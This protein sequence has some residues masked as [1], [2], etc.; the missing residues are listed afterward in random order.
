ME[1]RFG[2]PTDVQGITDIFNFYIENTN[3]RF[4]ELSL[5]VNNR[6][7]WFS[8]FSADSKYQIYVASKN[9]H[10]LG[11]AC[12]QP[13]RALEA[14][15]ETVEV[16]IYLDPTARGKGLGSA[17]YK[18]LFSALN[19]QKVHRILSAVALPN[20]ASV[21][22]HKSFGFREVGTFSEYATK[23]GQRISSVWLEKALDLESI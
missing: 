17:L 4:E 9:G 5:T 11:F 15:D 21:A 12:S 23:K 18:T 13:Y 22:L 8:Q 20:D 16:T 6:K 3:A 1:I 19:G 10:V 14:F 2:K 7:Q